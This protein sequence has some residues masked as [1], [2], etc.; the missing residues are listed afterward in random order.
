MC[1]FVPLLMAMCLLINSMTVSC[2]AL[3]RFQ[4]VRGGAKKRWE[5]SLWICLPSMLLIWSVCA[6]KGRDMAR[7]IWTVRIRE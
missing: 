7:A 2:I 6:G 3:D 4:A 5:P 1:N